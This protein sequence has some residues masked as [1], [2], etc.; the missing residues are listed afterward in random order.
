V[1]SLLEMLAESSRR[2]EGL[3]LAVGGAIR[4]AVRAAKESAE[5]EN[6]DPIKIEEVREPVFQAAHR[7]GSRPPI[8]QALGRPSSRL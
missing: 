8:V 1:T 2:S 5:D 7:P 6:D 4:A 3:Q